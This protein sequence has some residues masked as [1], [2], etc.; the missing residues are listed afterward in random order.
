MPKVKGQKE[1]AKFLKGERLT[2]RQAIL[3]QCFICNGEEEAAVDCKSKTCP[4]YPYHPYRSNSK[5]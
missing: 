3:A 4:L 2:Y 5:P 1:Y